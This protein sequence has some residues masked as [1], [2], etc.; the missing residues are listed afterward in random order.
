MCSIEFIL[1]NLLFQ[2]LGLTAL[3]AYLTRYRTFA[4]GS[5]CAGPPGGA[6][7]GGPELHG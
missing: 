2:F 7:P 3:S 6:S 1:V 4:A 5:G